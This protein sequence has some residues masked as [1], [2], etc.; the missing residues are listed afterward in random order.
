MEGSTEEMSGQD[1]ILSDTHTGESALQLISRLHLSGNISET[2]THAHTQS[3]TGNTC[4]HTHTHTHA[5]TSTH[6]HIHTQT[7]TCTHTH[8]HRHTH[9]YTHTTQ[10]HT[11]HTHVHA[12]TTHTHTYT[13]VKQVLPVLQRTPA[14][15]WVTLLTQTGITRFIRI[16]HVYRVRDE[17][18]GEREKSL[19]HHYIIAK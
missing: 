12:H 8:T 17:L 16:T 15:Y 7:H 2:V 5:A 6:T 1:P 14:T 11:P 19:H 10:L 18:R 9:T 13:P 3:H 4:T